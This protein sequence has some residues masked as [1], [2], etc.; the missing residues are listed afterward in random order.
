MNDKIVRLSDST[1]IIVAP[2]ITKDPVAAYLLSLP[3]KESKRTQLSA[4]RTIAALFGA[5]D[6]RR[7]EWISLTY[8]HALAVR[9]RLGTE[10]APATARRYFAAFRGVIREAWR[11]GI[12]SGEEW[13]RIEDITAPKGSSVETGRALSGDEIRKLFDATGDHYT[14]RRDAALV[15]LSVFA[16][17]RRFEAAGLMLSDWN[18]QSGELHIRGKGR[19]ERVVRI[20]QLARYHLRRWIVA[21]GDAPGPLLCGRKGQ[22]IGYST[23]D[24]IL[25]RVVTRAGVDHFTPH[26]MRRTFVTRILE[27]TGDI[28]IAQRSAGHAKP[29]TT[30][31]YDKRTSEAVKVATERLDEGI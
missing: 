6:P 2:A 8:M 30:V 21:R 10:H 9:D 22:A 24:A 17:L 20:A 3:S 7:L 28:A 11:L 23:I 1:E 16:G 5:A 27:M 13:R 26:D 19:K 4:L 12:F 25:G 18:D 14:G 15:A 31:R 29:E